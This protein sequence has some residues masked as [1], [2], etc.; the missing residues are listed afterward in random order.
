ME[1][2]IKAITVISFTKF[3]D[4]CVD[5]MMALVYMERRC[6]TYV[7]AEQLAKVVCEAGD[8]VSPSQKGGAKN[9]QPVPNYLCYRNQTQTRICKTIKK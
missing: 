3:I 6:C 7:T 9:S 4:K 8:K 2:N 1:K 5:I